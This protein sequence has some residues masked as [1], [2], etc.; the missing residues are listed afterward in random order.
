VLRRDFTP[1]FPLKLMDKDMRLALETAESLRIPMPL[2][3]ALKGVYTA[4]VASGLGEE[5]FA[6]LVKFLERYA[7]VEVAS[8]RTRGTTS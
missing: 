3:S 5:D 4:C 7:G 8:S 6:A 2:L 1:F